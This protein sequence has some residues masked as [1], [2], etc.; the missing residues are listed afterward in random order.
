MYY[1]RQRIY[2]LLLI[3]LLV[4]GTRNFLENASRTKI[5]SSDE[6]KILLKINFLLP[7][8][9]EQVMPNLK[10]IPEIPSSSIKTDLKWN[11]S[12]TLLL[13]LTQNS[14]PGSQ[15]VSIVLNNVPTHIP[16]VAKNIHKKK[17][18]PAGH[19]V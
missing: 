1:S 6:G 3:L 12:T 19:G 17:Y 7:V 9:K 16:F 14:L 18:F 15:E 4:L 5:V 13:E 11:N 8:K 10:I 2:I